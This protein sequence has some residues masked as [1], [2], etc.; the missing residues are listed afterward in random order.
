MQL[1]EDRLDRVFEAQRLPEHLRYGQERLGAL[2]CALELGDVE[3]DRVEADV[4]ALDAER[5]EH[6][7][8]VDRLSVLPDATS[9]PVGTASLERLAGDVLPFSAEVPG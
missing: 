7:L 8:H 9:D 1:A 5:Y 2:S 6:H 3:V 4:L